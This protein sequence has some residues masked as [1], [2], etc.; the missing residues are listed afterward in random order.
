MNIQQSGFHRIVKY[1]TVFT[2]PPEK[3]C[4]FH[5]RQTLP[6]S[7]YVSVDQLDDLKR[8]DKIEYFIE[9]NVD[10]ESIT[11]KSSPFNIYLYGDTAS[12]FVIQLPLHLR[13][14]SPGSSSFVKVSL[15]NPELFVDCHGQKLSN[16]TLDDHIVDLKC[17]KSRNQCKWTKI[18]YE[19]HSEP[20]AMNVPIGYENFSVLVTAVT[21]LTSWIGSFYIA[22]AITRKA[23]ALKNRL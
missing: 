7:A 2:E 17:R 14:H 8:F 6:S 13:Y 12:L 16:T 10:V 22:R 19:T 21:I 23:A 3:P 4:D 5:L 9:S 20:V 18:D 11:S 15:E 1:I